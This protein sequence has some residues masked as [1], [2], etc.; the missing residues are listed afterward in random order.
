M[1]VGAHA[2]VDITGFGLLGHLRLIAQG[3]AVSARVSVGAIPV[4]EGV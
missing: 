4:I 3:S 2:C 1:S